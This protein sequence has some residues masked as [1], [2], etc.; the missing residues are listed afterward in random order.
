MGK[1]PVARQPDPAVGSP[2]HAG[3]LRR[4][5]DRGRYPPLGSDGRLH[6]AGG[7]DCHLHLLSASPGAVVDAHGEGSG[8]GP[9]RRSRQTR[10]MIEAS[11]ILVALKDPDQVEELTALACLLAQAGK[12]KEILALHL[13]QIPRSLPLQTELTA[14][15]DTGHAMLAK[16]QVVAEE[17]FD[18]EN[19]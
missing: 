7:R 13:I 15:I 8:T 11:R 1:P 9:R 14:D 12:G 16:A 19:K 17:R 5:A 4:L 18:L 3:H 10:Q 6:L 2:R